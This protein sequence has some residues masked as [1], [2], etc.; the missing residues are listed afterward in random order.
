[1]SILDNNK[2][3]ERDLGEFNSSITL[4]KPSISSSLD[5]LLN[6]AWCEVNILDNQ[7]TTIKVPLVRGDPGTGLTYRGTVR[8]SQALPSSALVGDA[9]TIAST[10]L[11]VHWRRDGGWSKPFMWKGREG[12]PG[13][14]GEPA[15]PMEMVKD[16]GYTTVRTPQQLPSSASQGQ[17]VLAESNDLMYQFFDG[18]WSEGFKYKGNPG[19]PTADDKGPR[20]DKGLEA[21]RLVIGKA[22]D[23]INTADEGT[24]PLLYKFDTGFQTNNTTI[25]PSVAKSDLPGVSSPW[26]IT[27]WRDWKAGVTRTISYDK[28][29]K[30][31]IAYRGKKYNTIAIDGT[32]VIKGASSKTWYHLHKY[33][34]SKGGDWFV[35]DW[36]RAGSDHISFLYT[37]NLASNESENVL[38]LELGGSGS[39]IT[40]GIQFR[41]TIFD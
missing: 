17:L 39:G 2:G 1:M 16:F 33:E 37:T 6:E 27:D 14:K 38:K 29:L 20:G 4:R 10:G 21:D 11:T 41:I 9:W 31:L 5:G 28:G 25:T 22:E 7:D 3:W 24:K 34:G 26:V 40:V 30:R 13:D 35:R 36:C 18:S 12:E 15:A 23:Y 8:T 19:I 32:L